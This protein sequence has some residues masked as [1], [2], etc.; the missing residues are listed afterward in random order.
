[1]SAPLV[2][3]VPAK[4]RLQE[5]AENFF[6]RAGLRLVKPRGARDYRGTID[7]LDGVE[8]AY[9]SAAEIMLDRKPDMPVRVSF[10]RAHL[11]P[12]FVA[13]FSTTI[14]QDIPIL[15][16]VKSKALGTTQRFPLHL[17]QAVPSE[18]GHAEGV[19][20][21]SGDEITVTNS[22]YDPLAVVFSPPP[23]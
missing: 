14:K 4:G 23:S 1:M 5:N 15:V 16:T 19:A 22:N 3:A 10:R 12:G 11:G 6:A 8:I 21:D 17:S 7:G 2:I 9:L 13:V 20:I 18:L